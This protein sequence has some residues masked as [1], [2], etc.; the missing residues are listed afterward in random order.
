MSCPYLV[1]QATDFC[2][3]LKALKLVGSAVK[4]EA[5]RYT[6]EGITRLLELTNNEWRK[7]I[8]YIDRIN[9]SPTR[10]HAPQERG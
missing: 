9:V 6:E 2:Q 10:E 8:A 3:N 4:R 5:Q 1:V 7:A